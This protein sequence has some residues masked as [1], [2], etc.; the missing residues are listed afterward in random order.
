MYLYD[1]V[2]YKRVS[3]NFP[4]QNSTMNNIGLDTSNFW[5]FICTLSLLVFAF[6]LSYEPLFLAKHN[7][8]MNLLNEN[9]AKLAAKNGYYLGLTKDLYEEVKDSL[10]HGDIKYFYYS[11]SNKT[12]KDINNQHRDTILYY[13][14][15][16]SS[17]P[18]KEKIDSLNK[19]NYNYAEGVF[20]SKTYT[21]TQ[22]ALEKNI[23]Q[24]SCITLIFGILS[25][26]TFIW[27]LFKW[28]KS[29]HKK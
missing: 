5:K 2:I 15:Q 9:K 20:L 16:F 18:I 14:N 11:K 3:S 12:E 29:E 28:Y 25:L 17:K 24:R 21:F 23:A 19:L 22:N 8:E 4:Q 27:S 26:I 13:S 6:C 10:K 1:E 7:Q